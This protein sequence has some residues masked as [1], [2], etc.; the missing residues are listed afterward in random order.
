MG[1]DQQARYCYEIFFQGKC[2]LLCCCRALQLIIQERQQRQPG[3]VG[4]GLLNSCEFRAGFCW[5][6]EQPE[7]DA[8]IELQCHVTIGCIERSLQQ[9]QCLSGLILPQQQRCSNGSDTGGG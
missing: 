8:A 4:I 5:S 6:V 9:L 2:V 1:L 3:C 7:R